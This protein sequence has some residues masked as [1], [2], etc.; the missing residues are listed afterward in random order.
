MCV[1]MRRQRMQSACFCST[2]RCHDVMIQ[3]P[4]VA[5]S[6]P[7][8]PTPNPDPPKPAPYPGLLP[9]ERQRGHRLL[10][11]EAVHHE[12]ARRPVFSHA[13]QRL[14]R[15][16]IWRLQRSKQRRCHAVCLGGDP[17]GPA[18]VITQCPEGRTSLYKSPPLSSQSGREGT[19]VPPK[20]LKKRC[21]LRGSRRWKGGTCRGP[22]YREY[23]RLLPAGP[24]ALREEGSSLAQ[25]ING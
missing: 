10:Q 24:V 20:G 19:S 21:V 14:V 2:A 6:C 4:L 16:C 17:L 9:A 13:P 18:R 5:L 22:M 12:F 3:R 23:T 25:P 15:K 1:S 8:T 7:Q 11:P